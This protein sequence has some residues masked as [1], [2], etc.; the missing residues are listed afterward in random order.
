MELS[1]GATQPKG[2]TFINMRIAKKFPDY[3]Q[4]HIMKKVKKEMIKTSLSSADQTIGTQ[5]NPLDLKSKASS[6][7]K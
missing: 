4:R 3:V 5:A 7:Q 6:Q 1:S 2:A